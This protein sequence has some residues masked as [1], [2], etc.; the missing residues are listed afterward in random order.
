MIMKTTP[1]TLVAVAALLVGGAGVAHAADLPTF[2]L[3]GFPMTLHQAQTL[4]PGHVHEQAH[5]S[6]LTRDG[7]PASP[8]QLLVLKPKSETTET[9]RSV[10]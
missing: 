6:T 1:H 9:T 10:P 8:H 3:D 2:E 5:A 4:G 7:M